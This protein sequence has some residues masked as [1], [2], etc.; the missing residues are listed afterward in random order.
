MAT[1][2]VYLGHKVDAT[3][4]HTSQRKVEAIQKAPT[5][6]NVQQLKSFLGLV[7]Y[8]GKLIPHLSSLLH[9][10]NQLLKANVKWSWS[11][12]CE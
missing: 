8:Y 2:V 7:Q 3:G 9:P 6:K 5:P 4:I 10:L 1:L 12:A 11:V